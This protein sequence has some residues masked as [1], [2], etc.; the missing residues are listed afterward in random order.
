MNGNEVFRNGISDG[1][2]SESSVSSNTYNEVIYRQISLPIKVI[3]GDETDPKAIFYVKSGSNT[4]A[5][6]LVGSETTQNE[7]EFDCA[8]RLMSD[9]IESRVFDYDASSE[10]IN[11]KS[12]NDILTQFFIY[13]I[14]SETCSDNSF[15]INFNND[16]HEWIN[17]VTLIR[18]YYE[19]TNK[20]RQF[21]FEAR[22]ENG[23]ENGGEWT[24]LLDMN[25]I[26]W[27][28]SEKS[29]TFYFY[30]NKAYNQYRFINFGSGDLN[31]C[32]WELGTLDLNLVSTVFDIP[33]IAYDV[34]S[35]IV[36]K[37][38]RIEA[39]HPNSEYYYDFS[40][41]PALPNGLTMD[42][43]T[44]VISGIPL[45][46]VYETLYTI[47]AY[48]M[49]G[50]LMSTELSLTVEECSGYR[51]LVSLIIHTDS[52]P[53]DISYKIYDES[54][55]DPIV[56]GQGFSE[57][58]AM[59]YKDICLENGIYTLE[60]LDLNQNGWGA[61]AGY[62]LAVDRD[63]LIFEMG[64]VPDGVASV[65]TQFSAYLP[66]QIEYSEW[67]I[68]YGF[69]ENWNWLVFDDS[70]WESK[71]A[72]EI[73][74]NENVTTYLRKEVNI[75]VASDYRVLNVRMKYVGGVVAYYNGF[76]V[77]RFNLKADFTPETMA[78]KKHD[79]NTFSKFHVI[80]PMVAHIDGKNEVAFEIHRSQDESSSDPVVF[81]ATGVFGVNKCSILTNSY[82][83]VDENGDVDES[84]QEY[85]EPLFD[86]IPFTFLDDQYSSQTSVEWRIDNLENIKFNSF[87]IQTSSSISI[88][89]FTLSAPETGARS[90]NS[91][92]ELDSI[93]LYG[94]QRNA[95]R[96]PLNRNGYSQLKFETKNGNT[97]ADIS[98]FILQYDQS[99]E[100]EM[101]PGADNYPSVG[102]GEIS[103]VSCRYGYSG[104]SYRICSGGV[105][106]EIQDEFCVQNKIENLAYINVGSFVLFKG[107]SSYIP[108]PAYD[109]LVDEFYLATD[110]SL[111]AGL[112]LDEK[113]GKITGTPTKVS[114][115]G[116]YTIYA[117]NEVSVVQT[118]IRIEV[119]RKDRLYS[120][121]IP[122][123]EQYL[124][125]YEP[126][127]YQEIEDY[128]S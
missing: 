71:K 12:A 42:P 87:G 78:D 65:S 31:S 79:A 4:I 122:G 45:E 111:P 118:T 81:D 36:Y 3:L 2:I 32:K 125:D 58:S 24:R 90:Y 97:L 115:E 95:W 76:L 9:Q 44:G 46:S 14:S 119:K 52:Y 103:T 69:V 112:T 15:T 82:S 27:L 89:G 92:L 43:L 34:N 54:S 127:E 116:T 114:E 120:C 100:R 57:A 19:S 70:A 61:K 10:G 33:D 41:N 18:A 113:T 117:K 51:S 68:S 48:K 106:G 25:N 47:S 85:F 64:Q 91:L 94:T 98:S 83:I 21:S 35:L 86:L 16:R 55:Q 128:I 1:I 22:N 23:N 77:A 39:M 110:A 8:L 121:G 6:G 38:E 56:T 74:T 67:K 101:C 30:N 7:V 29:K 126:K 60:L 50:E 123:Y 75:P 11:G 88:Y 73:G 99:K 13:T 93:T 62:Y 40:V 105:L 72:S 63:L 109:N 28:E 17:S 20:P 49:T 37:Y 102:E 59:V 66:F 96:I 107:R 5:I 53:Q 104:F 26:E 84:Q 80:L 124:N 108:G